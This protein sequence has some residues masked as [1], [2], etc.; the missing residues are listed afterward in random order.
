MKPQ[1]KISPRQCPLIILDTWW[2]DYPSFKLSVSWPYS[3]LH[4]GTLVHES[5]VLAVNSC[6]SRRFQTF[7]GKM[8]CP[9]EMSPLLLCV[10]HWQA[11]TITT[12]CFR[13]SAGKNDGFV[14]AYLR[15]NIKKLRKPVINQRSYLAATGAGRTGC[16]S[17]RSTRTKFAVQWQAI[18]VTPFCFKAPLEKMMN[19]LLLIFG[20]TYGS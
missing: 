4:D 16:P 3:Q 10:F 19:F 8:R 9:S 11:L 12:F 17:K 5:Y 1:V 2:G 20:E 14:V 6:T 18:T 13:S 7:L 15:R